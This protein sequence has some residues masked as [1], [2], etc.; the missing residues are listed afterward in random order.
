MQ[1]VACQTGLSKSS[2]HRLGQAL[3]RRTAPAEETPNEHDS[4]RTPFG[5]PQDSQLALRALGAVY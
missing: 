2:V 3:E 4:A 5:T 1:Q